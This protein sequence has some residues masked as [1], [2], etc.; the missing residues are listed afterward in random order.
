MTSTYL[1]KLSTLF[2]GLAAAVLL[3]ACGDVD[4]GPGAS[5]SPEEKAAK[6]DDE[7]VSPGG[8]VQISH[9]IVGTPIVGQPLSID[10]SLKSMRGAKP[11]RVD[12]RIN[13]GSALAFAAQQLATTTALPDSQS[14]TAEQQV[15][16]VPQREGRLYLNV[17]VGVET[18]M[19]MSSTVMAIPIQVGSG[20]RSFEENGTLTT[21]ANGN[22][23][24]ALP[25]RPR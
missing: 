22:A 13:D 24:R 1:S 14:M 4:S 5:L 19:G 16:V 23:I 2:P 9:R 15:T 12:Y 18:D 17:S 11:L 10:L 6:I 21:D 20:P 8:P 3:A 7:P 25:A